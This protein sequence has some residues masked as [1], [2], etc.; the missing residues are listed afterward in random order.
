MLPDSVNK[1]PKSAARIAVIEPWCTGCGGAPVCT[2][3]CKK[4][5]LQ[6]TKDQEVY[7]FHMMT[8][9][10]ELCIGCGACVSKGK[11]GIMLSGCPWNAIRM[12]TLS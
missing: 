12:E 7:P 9:N 4:N 2:V 8:V 5:A 10:Q 1:K 3:Y 6:L 11:Q